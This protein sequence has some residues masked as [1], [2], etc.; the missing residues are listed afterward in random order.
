MGRILGNQMGNDSNET[1]G[2]RLGEFEKQ[3]TALLLEQES[4]L[5]LAS[6]WPLIIGRSASHRIRVVR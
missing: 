4:L 3:S 1:L 2:M 6:F 5:A